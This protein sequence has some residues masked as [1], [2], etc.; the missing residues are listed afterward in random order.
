MENASKALLIAAA[1]LIVILIIAF[2]M[3]IFNSA[4]D[5]SADATEVGEQI[6]AQSGLAADAATGAIDGISGTKT[7]T[8]TP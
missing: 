8:P 4:G 7:P 5:T 6:T 3:K 1:V 2:G